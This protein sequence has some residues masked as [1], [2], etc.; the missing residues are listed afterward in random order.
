MWIALELCKIT[1][2]EK[3]QIQ[4]LNVFFTAP[5]QCP[6]YYLIEK[7][8]NSASICRYEKFWNAS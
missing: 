1:K 7:I 4:R 6:L 2:L 5:F 8:I 3:S